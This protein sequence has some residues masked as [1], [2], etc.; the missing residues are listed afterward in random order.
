MV[1]CSPS[2]AT[3][4]IV[5]RPFPPRSRGKGAEAMAHLDRGPLPCYICQRKSRGGRGGDTDG[6][7][8]GIAGN[9]GEPPKRAGQ[10]GGPVL[11]GP[12]GRSGGQCRPRGAGGL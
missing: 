8:D 1:R 10:P 11:P 4:P 5:Q 6:Q 12:G 3:A 9:G 7:P 2:A